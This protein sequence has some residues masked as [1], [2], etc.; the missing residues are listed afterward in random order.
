MIWTCSQLGALHDVLEKLQSKRIS[1]WEKKFGR[2]PTVSS[3][4]QFYEIFV[5]RYLIFKIEQNT[6]IPSLKSHIYHLHLL[7]KF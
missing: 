6:V 2:V 4:T 1:L 3:T 5:F 7:L